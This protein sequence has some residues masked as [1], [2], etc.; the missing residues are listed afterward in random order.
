MPYRNKVYVAFDGD[1]DMIYYSLLKAWNA[2]E[3]IDFSF[4]NAHDINYAR[5]ASKEESIKNQLR[6]RL[7][8]TK[9]L[10]LLVGANTRFLY[11]FVRW[12]LEEALKLDIP[13]IAVNLNG[14]KSLDVDRCPAIIRNRFVVHI[15]FNR[16]AINYAIVHWPQYYHSYKSEKGGPMYY[17]DDI[18]SLN[19]KNK[20]K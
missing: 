15:G 14:K 5:D 16:G 6:V 12:E 3:N 9:V 11:K 1:N 8:N 10:V 19:D 13:I 20:S 2:N 17:G 18:Y 4:Y 7:Q